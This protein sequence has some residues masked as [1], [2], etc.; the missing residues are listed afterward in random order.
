MEGARDRTTSP[1]AWARLAVVT[2]LIGV[3]VTQPVL[4]LFGRNPT[5]FTAGPYGRSQIVAFALVV[6]LG[7]VAVAAIV[8]AVAARLPPAV[9]RGV[10]LVVLAGLGAVFGNVLLRGLGGDDG[11]LAIVAA[12]AGA[13]AVV[14]IEATRPGRMLL[15]YL[16]VGNVLFLVSFLVLSPTADLLGGDPTGDLG[17]ASM[18]TP[19]GPVVVVVLD[20]LPITTL[21]RPD[22]TINAARFP[23]FA[24]LA[25][26]STWYRNA[27]THHSVTNVAVPTL[28]TG[29][30]AQ[31]DQLPSY[32]A[33]PRN[34]FTLVGDTV[35]IEPYEPITNMC[36]A[37][38][39]DPRPHPSLTRGLRDAG[40][41]YAHR[42]LPPDLRNRFP[43]IGASW[44][45]FG[46]DLGG[47]PPAVKLPPGFKPD[48]FLK[49]LT[50]PAH[51]KN[52]PGQA[53]VLAEHT[54]AIDATP[55]LHL[56]H[57]L[58][59]HQPWVVSPFGWRLLEAP[60][61][62]EDPDD[63]AFE[64]S[65]RQQ[66][67]LHSMQAGAADAAVG[68]LI[69]HLDAEGV[70]DDTTLVITSDHGM[71]L[72][73]GGYGRERTAGN[74]QEL[75]RVPLFIHSPELAEGEVVDA[76]AQSIDLLPTL[77]DL[78]HVDTDW[79]FDGHSLVDGSR[80]TVE[81]IVGRP[82]APALDVV[83]R[84]AADLPYGDTWTALAA[85]G[86]HGALVGRP[87]ADLTVGAPSELGWTPDHE[88]ELDDLPTDTGQAPQLVTGI[89][90]SPSG[91]RPPE[92]VVVVNGTVAGV[93]GGYR[94]DGAAWRFTAFLGPFL[95][96]GANQIDAYEVVAGAGG[97]TLRLLG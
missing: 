91:D 55:A 36:P 73:T 17:R 80:L 69:D 68:N 63:P 60:K 61:R 88:A 96:E 14:V 13:A 24:E 43:D 44:G 31:D 41:V 85:V 50:L 26:R 21:L 37:T 30:L 46:D 71:G 1:S 81:P 54:A 16:A 75:F 45:G 86:E 94:A 38:L 10:Y 82:F 12:L 64:W 72:T 35:P 62:I 33:H 27:S 15:Q 66:Y 77:V 95:V 52:P 28:L 56:I 57:V 87:L 34:L 18:P 78:L 29:V 84:H 47:G 59:P 5:F 39:C 90:E 6:A 70:W 53:A 32:G 76:P 65:E 2:G 20:E 67:Q 25:E 4:D 58:F 51:E 19:P 74:T 93:A 40:V 23:R 97:P 89:V 83:R 3:A 48:P 11:R 79:S 8:L 49:Y 7:P 92:L 9:S 22:G 42:V